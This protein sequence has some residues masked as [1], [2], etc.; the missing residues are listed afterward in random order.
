MTAQE[1]TNT[2]NNIHEGIEKSKCGKLDS[3]MKDPNGNVV[4]NGLAF[5]TFFK[6]VEATFTKEK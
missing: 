3:G 4:Y 2:I 5:N 1:I 6:I